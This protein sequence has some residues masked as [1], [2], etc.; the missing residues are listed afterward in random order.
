MVLGVGDWSDQDGEYYRHT[1]GNAILEKA[2]S[3]YEYQRLLP[4]GRHS[5]NGKK[6][7]LSTDFNGVVKKDQKKEFVLKDDQ[8]VLK[9]SLEQVEET[10]PKVAISYQAVKKPSAS[11]EHQ[12]N[13]PITR[14]KAGSIIQAPLFLIISLAAGVLFLLGSFIIPTKKKTTRSRRHVVTPNRIFRSI[15]LL[16]LLSVAVQVLMTILN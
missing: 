15:G 3:E 7:Q 11:K 1:F 16:C 6:I 13:V 10:L 4:K 9:S 5:I 2:F 8:L 14:K 12:K